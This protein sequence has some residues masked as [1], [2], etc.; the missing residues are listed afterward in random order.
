MCQTCI[1][2]L[3]L[4]DENIIFGLKNH[5]IFSME[6]NLIDYDI[7]SLKQMAG[8]EDR[9]DDFLIGRSDH[10][11]FGDLIQQPCRVNA[12][13]IALCT[14]GSSRC[15]INLKEYEISEGALVVGFPSNIFRICHDD[16]TVIRC[17]ML[18]Q[19]FMRDMHIELKEALPLFM[20]V[21]YNPVLKVDGSE[22]REVEK[23]FD[24]LEDVQANKL[25]HRL[26]ISR[27]LVSSL[28]YRIGDMYNRPDRDSA[29]QVSFSA[30]SRREEYFVRFVHLLAEDF[31]TQRTVGYYASRLCITPKYLSLIIKETS[32]RSAAEWID[33]YVLTEA[34][35]LL[36]FTTMSIQ[37]VAY[38]LN[39][40]S[41]SF[42]GK[43]FKH[44][45][46]MS[47]SEYKL[48]E[49]RKGRDA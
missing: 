20:K 6:Q 1:G 30:R 31:R 38:A 44:L 48:S 17:A 45:T 46:G 24:L 13:M 14:Q 37:E 11:V 22:R 19:R 3:V 43:Y 39:F 23:Y 7:S 8:V 16:K 34:K 41:Q 15:Y 49:G 35:T 25:Q 42:F 2:L 29:S 4:T 27:G 12:H 40:S 32:G 21:A 26:E 10:I 47:P 36:K 33:A 9:D 5:S 18:S 28:W